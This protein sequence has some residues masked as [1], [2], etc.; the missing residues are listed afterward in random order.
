[1]E[2]A[3]PEHL[4]CLRTRHR[5]ITDDYTPAYPATVARYK[6]DVKQVVM[7]YFGVQY[8]GA[9]SPD[10][11][12]KALKSI[13]SAFG[14][15]EG[16]GHCDRALYIDEA[17]FT[18]G[19]SVGYWD[20][21]AK[22][23][24]WFGRYGATSGN[25]VIAEGAVGAFAE[26]PRPSIE[27]F[28]T[29]FS[30]ND[31]EWVACLADGFSDAIQEHAYWGSAR[32][33]VP[34]SQ[35]HDMAPIGGP[36]LATE[37]LRQRVIPHENICL[38]RSGRDWSATQTDERRMYLQDVESVLRAGMDFLR[39]DGLQIGCFANRYMTVVDG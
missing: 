36:R 16:P 21:P 33:R 12:D 38:I 7:A 29:L 3:I 30:S 18:N 32:D 6:P 26:V 35:T 39:D 11:A 19:I 28:D 1:M 2:S 17:S 31:P 37:G 23:D 14:S 34:M 27:R 20:A 13:A 22:F 8:R 10:G 24:P 5:R 15:A 4:Q 25:D 9:L